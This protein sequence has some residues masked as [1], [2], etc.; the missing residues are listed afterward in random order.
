MSDSEFIDTLSRV[1]WNQITDLFQFNQDTKAFY[2]N[3]NRMNV[4]IDE[5]GLWR[6]RNIYCGTN[7]ER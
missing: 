7:S 5:L 3:S 4:I 6:K 2:Q 1:S